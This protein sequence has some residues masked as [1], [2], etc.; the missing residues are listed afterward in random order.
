MTIMR[1]IHNLFFKDENNSSRLKSFFD[2]AKI[3]GKEKSPN[4]THVF[5][6]EVPGGMTMEEWLNG[7]WSKFDRREEKDIQ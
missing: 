3:T 7:G 4:E 2:G 6:T 5:H 1:F